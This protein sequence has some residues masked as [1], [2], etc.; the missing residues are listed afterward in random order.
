MESVA[1][2][3]PGGIP[4]WLRGPLPV[5]L[6]VPVLAICQVSASE[7]PFLVYIASLVGVNVVKT[8]NWSNVEFV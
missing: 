1:I 5:M 6:A 4:A 3:R 7:S 8:I 2:A